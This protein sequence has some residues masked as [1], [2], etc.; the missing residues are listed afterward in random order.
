M[1]RRFISHQCAGNFSQFVSNEK[2]QTVVEI[3]IA[4]AY[5]P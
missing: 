2:N 5:L 3:G 4:G 1:A